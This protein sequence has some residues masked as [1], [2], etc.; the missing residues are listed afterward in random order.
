MWALTRQ[1]RR[2]STEFLQGVGIAED[3]VLSFS[4]QLLTVPSLVQVFEPLLLQSLMLAL[5]DALYLCLKEEEGS[6]ALVF[7]TDHPAMV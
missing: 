4:V 6:R 3:T 1:Y 2:L 7:C 5:Q